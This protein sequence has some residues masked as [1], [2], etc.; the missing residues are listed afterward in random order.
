MLKYSGESSTCILF[1]LSWFKLCNKFVSEHNV[2]N[3]EFMDDV[4]T[5]YFNCLICINLLKV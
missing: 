1:Y 3:Y 5:D 2:I 4:S